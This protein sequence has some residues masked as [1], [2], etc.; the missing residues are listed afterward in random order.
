MYFIRNSL[1]RER[2]SWEHNVNNNLH[3]SSTEGKSNDT[4]TFYLMRGFRSTV[5]VYGKSASP[6]T[7]DICTLE[8]CER[9]AKI[10]VI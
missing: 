4:C 7:D 5:T 6:E 1:C 3:R 2:K 10:L 8:V 9:V